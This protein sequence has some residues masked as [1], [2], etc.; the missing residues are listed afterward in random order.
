MDS[1]DQHLTPTLWDAMA[2]AVTI[3]PSLC[4]T[5]PRRIEID[6]RG[7]TREV[8]GEPNAQ[9]CLESDSERFFRMYFATVL[10]GPTLTTGSANR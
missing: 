1:F 7:Y 3:E 6:D 4:R 10:G 8:K 5:Q 9:V 2:V